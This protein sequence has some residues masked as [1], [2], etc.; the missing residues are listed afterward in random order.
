MAYQTNPD[1]AISAILATC[2]FFNLLILGNYLE[3]DPPPGTKLTLACS[4]DSLHLCAV[5]RRSRQR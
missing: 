5:R 1:R 3:N 2:I 4:T